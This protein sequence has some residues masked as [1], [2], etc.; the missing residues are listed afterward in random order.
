MRGLVIFDLRLVIQT[1]TK[2]NPEDDESFFFRRLQKW[3]QFAFGDEVGIEKMGSHEQD[4]YLGRHQ[5]VF[6]FLLTGW[7]NHNLKNGKDIH[8]YLP[9]VVSQAGE[10]GNENLTT[11]NEYNLVILPGFQLDQVYFTL[12]HFD[13]DVAGSVIKDQEEQK[14]F[15]YP[16]ERPIVIKL[17]STERSLSHEYYFSLSAR[18]KEG[19]S[20]SI[21]GLFFFPS[22][23]IK[24]N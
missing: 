6:N 21:E 23:D 18:I 11:K 13:D 19:G 16:A 15:F 2:V 1:A 22:N 9:I 17:S 20:A 4:R 24:V 12:Q 8:L 7:I 5:G 3:W 10:T 14:Q